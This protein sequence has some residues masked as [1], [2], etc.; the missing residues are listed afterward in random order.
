MATNKPRITISLQ[1]QTYEALSRLSRAG[2]QPMASIVSEL[3]ESAAP[4]LVRMA[5]V[6]ERAA[7]ASEEVR[8][9]FVAA[10]ERAERDLLPGLMEQLGQAELFLAD[11]EAATSA[12]DA[13]RPTRTRRPKRTPV[14]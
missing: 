3:V 10:V 4:S 8:T 1:P 5:V 12:A 9:G 6:I 13:Q 7:S 2:H 14:L 11:C